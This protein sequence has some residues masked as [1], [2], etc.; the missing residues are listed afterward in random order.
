MR[1]GEEG[2]SR[3]VEDFDGSLG[4]QRVGPHEHRLFRFARKVLEFWQVGFE[5]GRAPRG[6]HHDYAVDRRRAGDQTCEFGVAEF[7]H[8]LGCEIDRVLRRAVGRHV[9]IKRLAC[10]GVEDRH[11]EPGGG[12]SIRHPDAGAAGSGADADTAT[13]RHA[14]ATGEKA[15]RQVQHFVEVASFNQTVAIEHGAVRRRGAGQHGGV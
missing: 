8:A 11:L 5:K 15:D 10:R 12:A 7:L 3:L 6:D 9:S 2:I 4:R 14:V 1:G 13:R